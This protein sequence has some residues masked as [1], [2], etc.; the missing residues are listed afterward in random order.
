MLFHLV[1]FFR[2]RK[3]VY[4]SII[5]VSALISPPEI[6]TQFL[7]SLF[8][9]SFYEILVFFSYWYKVFMNTQAQKIVIKSL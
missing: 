5:F 4:V 3:Y 6:V 9:V 1:F 8:L 2:Y 7:V